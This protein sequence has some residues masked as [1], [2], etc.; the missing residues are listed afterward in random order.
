MF[1]SD[2]QEVMCH[3]VESIFTNA[4]KLGGPP[5]VQ[6][7]A[8]VMHAHLHKADNTC[9]VLHTQILTILVLAAASTIRMNNE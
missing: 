2:I 8:Q 1:D 4:V 6:H 5:N 9:M 7:T 3:T